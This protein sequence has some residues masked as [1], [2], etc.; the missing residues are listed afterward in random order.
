[1][2]CNK[3]RKRIMTVAVKE[4]TKTEINLWLLLSFTKNE[5]VQVV[6]LAPGK[7]MYII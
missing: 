1:M 5:G 4:L 3:K 6:H 2:N 7:K